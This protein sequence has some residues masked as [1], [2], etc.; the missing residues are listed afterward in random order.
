MAV[1][2]I[3]WGRSRKS[4]E[5]QNRDCKRCQGLE[6]IGDDFITYKKHMNC[7]LARRLRFLKMGE[8]SIALDSNVNIVSTVGCILRSTTVCSSASPTVA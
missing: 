7:E 1:V 5:G 3:S 2:T 6:R 4:R 8:R